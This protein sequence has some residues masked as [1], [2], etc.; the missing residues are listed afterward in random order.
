MSKKD[1]ILKVIGLVMYYGALIGGWVIATKE[2]DS[3]T[4][5][6]L[7]LSMLAFTVKGNFFTIRQIQE[8]KDES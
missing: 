6:G 7:Y 1:K 8:L 4:V 2:L 5:A 3:L